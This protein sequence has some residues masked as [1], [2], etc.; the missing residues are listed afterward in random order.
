MGKQSAKGK[1]GA[2]A[3]ASE[4][5]ICIICGMA[6]AGI[7]S[8]PEFPV[9][10]AR[11]LR[12]I[13]KQPAKHTIACGEH[14]DEAREKRAKYEKKQRDYLIGAVLVVAFIILGSFVFGRAD[15]GLFMPALLGALLVALLPYF[16][17]F[18]S[19]G[20]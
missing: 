9:R 10:E 8:K 16:Y 11:W 12:S 17:Y 1:P 19:F 3:Q 15:A 18:P 7:P 6:R 13:L 2:H 5:G 14:L 20:K 4:K